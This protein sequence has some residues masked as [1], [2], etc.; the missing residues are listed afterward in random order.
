MSFAIK[1]LGL[2]ESQYGSKYGHLCQSAVLH[3][4]ITNDILCATKQKCSYAEFDDTAN[5]DQMV[6]V[7][8]VILCA[9][10]G[11]GPDPKKSLNC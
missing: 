9:C 1:H 11:L 4:I 6:P 7:L 10:L 8:V 2:N 3:K 5:C